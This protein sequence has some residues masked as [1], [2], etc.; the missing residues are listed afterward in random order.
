MNVLSHILL[1]FD[2]YSEA[3]FKSIKKPHTHDEMSVC[4]P[5]S[6]PILT[7]VAGPWQIAIIHPWSICL[8]S[9][10]LPPQI[11]SVI[12]TQPYFPCTRSTAFWASPST[13]AT[14]LLM[15]PSALSFIDSSFPPHLWY[16]NH[17]YPCVSCDPS[18]MK[19][20]A[21]SK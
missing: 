20:H 16:C 21:K 11:T 18:L 12:L 13:F 10:P 17:L 4:L 15:P 19:W 8:L 6:H 1:H 3:H 14:A 7:P 9:P 5:A 2:S